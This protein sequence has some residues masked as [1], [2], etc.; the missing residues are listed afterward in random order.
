MPAQT[1]LPL[2][3]LI[4]ILR[5]N[6]GWL[7][8]AVDEAEASRIIKTPQATLQTKR[9]RGGGPI[10]TKAGKRVLYIRR[11]LFD[12][13]AAGRRTSTSDAANR[14]DRLVLKETNSLR[15]NSKDYQRLME[16][17]KSRVVKLRD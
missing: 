6:P 15:K 10:F 1:P 12:W 5:D 8:E 16:A 2:P 14:R 17:S 9:V 3:S 7:D 4:E 11:D 13:L